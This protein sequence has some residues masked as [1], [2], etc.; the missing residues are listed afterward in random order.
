M[1][2]ETQIEKRGDGKEAIELWGQ[3]GILLFVT[4]KTGS[5]FRFLEVY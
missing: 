2:N 5:F 1:E 4:I 3:R